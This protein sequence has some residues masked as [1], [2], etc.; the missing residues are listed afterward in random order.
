MVLTAP[1]REARTDSGES[2]ASSVEEAFVALSAA[3]PEG[4]RVELIEGEIHVVPPANGEHEEIVSE[5]ADQVT[6][7]RTNKELRTRTGLGLLV[8]EASA[9]GKVVP[10]IVIAP[11]GSFDDSLEYHD[12]GAVMLVGE[13]TSH[14]TA[15]NDR[16]PK[17]RGY[18][19]AGIPFYLL[20]DRERK[21][22]VLHSLPAGK[23]YTRKVEV[24]ISQ[25]LSLPEPLGFDLDTSEF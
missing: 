21:Q 4:W 14:S 8:P 1:E 25:P 22:A 2:T 18:A 23:R 9:T 15:D 17:L 6:S 10:D 20:I 7:R 5:V 13:V 24:D 3:A 19:A 12:P 11:K 16:G